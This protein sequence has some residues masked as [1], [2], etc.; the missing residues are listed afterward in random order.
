MSDG[1]ANINFFANVTSL[2]AAMDK[3]IRKNQEQTDSLTKMAKASKKGMS[4]T[5]KATAAAAREMD[6]FAK[7]TKEV[8]RTPLEKYADEMLKLNRALKAGKI[9]QEDFRRASV[10][11]KGEFLG[12]ADAGNKAF[13]A[14]SLSS[15]AQYA[16][17]V[18]SIGAAAG[19]V[20]NAFREAYEQAAAYA[21][22]QRES[23]AGIGGLAQT[24]NSIEDMRAA[25]EAS[26][27]SYKQ[28]AGANVGEAGILQFSITSAL[29]EKYRKE[30]AELQASG[31]TPTP[32][33]MV[34]AAA[35]MESSMG[36]EA[37]G[38]FRNIVSQAFGAGEIGTTTAE[39]VLQAAAKSGP[40][41]KSLGFNVPELLA[42][43]S[44][45]SKV[46]GSAEEAQTLMEGFTKQIEKE[47]IGTGRLKRG[48]NLMEYVGDI[49]QLESKGVSVRNVL[50]D[51]QEAITGY[52]ILRD[53]PELFKANLT[54][55]VRA[56]KEDAF[57]KKVELYKAI[58]EMIGSRALKQ[59]LAREDVAATDLGTWTNLAESIRADMRA[60]IRKRGGLVQSAGRIGAVVN[61]WSMATLQMVKGPEE[62]VRS[63]EWAASPETK[64]MIRA[65]REA[66]AGLNEAAEN[67]NRATDNSGRQRAAAGITPE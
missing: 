25:Y 1:N 4:D 38:G 55:T 14:A 26:Q 59:S 64:E 52:R 45:L 32:I 21:A 8:N 41:A 6:R 44:T 16:S 54:N 13:G 22:K 23:F 58:P 62:F 18:F 36:T 5:E 30:I 51:R 33:M 15:L 48:R 47:G 43:I 31:V 24:S 49:A 28:G 39:A 17:G 42:G 63:H 66:M 57:A 29:F 7:H 56:G 53:N 37:T 34:N 10:K 11:A 61:D 19:V 46:S 65:V 27:E 60:D 9:D 35:A 3:S 2:L 40:Q 50:G 20:T 12:V 67:L